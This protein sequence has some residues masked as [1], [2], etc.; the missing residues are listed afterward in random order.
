MAQ[1]QA[2]NLLTGG[3]EALKTAMRDM[4]LSLKASLT[5]SFKADV[6]R[7]VT[8]D[9][10]TPELLEKLII[11]IAGKTRQHS[12]INESQAIEFVLPETVVGLS[13]LRD[14]PE[15]LEN[16]PLTELVFGLTRDML[17]EGVTFKTSAD[18]PSGV[19]IKLKDRDVTLDF[20]DQSVAAMLLEHLQP[21]FRAI[22]EGVVR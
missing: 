13:E 22:L 20:T 6:M 19:H 17:V 8:K 16:S 11:E 14:A 10:Q 9:M 7:L 3:Q 2:D 12:D 1:Q 18:I 5:D 4:A 15:K 21:R